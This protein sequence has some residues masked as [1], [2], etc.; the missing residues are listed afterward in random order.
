MNKNINAILELAENNNG[1]LNTKALTANGFRR[2]LLAVMVEEGLLV[3][4]ARGV[5][6]L[7]DREADVYDVI[8]KSCPKA[9]F[10]YET[11][12]YFHGLLTDTA[13]PEIISI[14]VQ[15][16]FNI[17]RLKNKCNNLKIH[18]VQPD[19]L[20]LGLLT[21]RSLSGSMIRLY[22]PER[23]ICDFIK[24]KSA[25]DPVYF[26]SVLRSYFASGKKNLRQLQTYA[27]TYG[28][29]EK[30]LNYMEVLM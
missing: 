17:T 10:S 15:Q 5:Y 22:D 13:S 23:C 19:F 16:G 27:H 28:I 30:V 25:V 18:Y 1:R 24:H 7:P 12:F 2:D 20:E 6:R 11:A 3:R 29:E 21:G 14:T 9:V 8:Q 4:E 26:S